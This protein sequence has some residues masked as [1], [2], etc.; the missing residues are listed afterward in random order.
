MLKIVLLFI[1]VSVTTTEAAMT[2]RTAAGRSEVTTS[3]VSSDAATETAQGTLSLFG[4]ISVCVA[5]NVYITLHLFV[6]Y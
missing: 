2:T 6:N 5:A 4:R 3:S 1:Y